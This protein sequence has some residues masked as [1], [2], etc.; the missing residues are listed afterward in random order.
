MVPGGGIINRTERADDQKQAD[1][2]RKE[3][4][5][6]LRD[7]TAGREVGEA[8]NEARAGKLTDAQLRDRLMKIL[9]K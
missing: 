9:C 4:E 7:D 2:G 8:L 5:T 6:E 3:S 1:S